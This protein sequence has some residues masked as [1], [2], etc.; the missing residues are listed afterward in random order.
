VQPA[1]EAWTAAL[2]A[3]KRTWF[4][5]KVYIGGNLFYP[6]GLVLAPLAETPPTIV[7]QAI[8]MVVAVPIVIA[9]LPI[10]LSYAFGSLI[11]ACLDGV[12]HPTYFDVERWLPLTI[13]LA[14]GLFALNLH[15]TAGAKTRR[16]FL[17]LMLSLVLFITSGLVGCIR[18]TLAPIG[19]Q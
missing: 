14:Y 18:E 13:P 8:G 15:L 3:R 6:I 5:W 9:L 11:A 17:L 1:T 7:P 16:A 10:G 12:W 2:A 19:M 4:W